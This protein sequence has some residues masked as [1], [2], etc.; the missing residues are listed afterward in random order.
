MLLSYEELSKIYGSGYNIKKAIKSGEIKKLEKGVYSKDSIVVNPLAI[1]GYKYPKSILTLNTALY[2]YNLTDVIPNKI[3]VATD[4]KAAKIND[5]RVMQIYIPKQFLNFGTTS[6]SILGIK[7][8]IYD[9]ERLLVEVLRRKNKLPFS[10]YKEV[11]NNYREIICDLDISKIN[12][13][14]SK[15][16]NADKLLKIFQLEVL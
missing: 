8:N 4:S 2:Y 11:I 13:Y 5:E 10:Y 14:I 12:N 9:R 1:I 15:F 16:N 7:I 6:I 3:Y